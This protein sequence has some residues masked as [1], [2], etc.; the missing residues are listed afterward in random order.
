[1]AEHDGAFPAHAR[2]RQ[3]GKEVKEVEEVKEKDKEVVSA[4]LGRW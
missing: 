3:E 1:M 2:A 4:G